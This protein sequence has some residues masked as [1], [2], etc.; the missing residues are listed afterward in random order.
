M[1]VQVKLTIIQG[2]LSGKEFIFEERSICIIGRH[3]NCHIRLPNN[4]EHRTISRYHCILDINYPYVQI[5]DF[6]S[7][8]GTYINGKKIGKLQAKYKSEATAKMQFPEYDLKSGDK[9]QLGTTIFQLSIETQIEIPP[10]TISIPKITQ[11]E[12]IEL[13]AKSTKSGNNNIII[14]IPKGY[15]FIKL[16][17]KGR[18]GEVYLVRNT[19]TQKL[20][21]FKTILPEVAIHSQAINRFL[22]EIENIKA[23]NHRNVVKLKDYSYSEQRFFLTLEYC[24]GDSIEDLLDRCG[25]RLS[26]SMSVAIIIQALDGL[27][28]AH[29]A[30][31][32]YIQKADGSFGTGKGLVH[33]RIKPA[34]I[35]I[36]NINSSTV[37]KI[38]NYGIAKAFNLAGFS[39]QIIT[40]NKGETFRFM[41]RQ[42]IINFKHI[43]PEVDVWA[44]AATLYN[45]LTGEY[46]R[47][48]VGKDPI[49]T[50]LQTKP[51]PIRQRNI[52]I[53]QLLAE[54]IDLA[55]I[56]EPE[57]F[58]KTAKEFRQALLTSDFS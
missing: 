26:I 50:I 55:L 15:R 52:Y 9:I 35:F 56:D 20:M 7:K 38:A 39:R 54:V 32:P 44:M 45:M 49:L 58:F 40:R 14:T 51:V 4:E 30:E 17:D 1:F 42:Q 47:D 34:N 43:K 28:Y 41:P 3:H 29:N 2:S 12:T 36:S 57:I 21:V 48:F 19:S 5:Y 11:T 53:P 46:P 24:N 33:G 6:G 8:N 23:L 16:L 13:S 18:L 25:D 31:I 37:V 22:V 10:E 27:E